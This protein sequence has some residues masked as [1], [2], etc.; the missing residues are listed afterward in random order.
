MGA[1]PW[2]GAIKYVL[3][4]IVLIGLLIAAADLLFGVHIGPFPEYKR[5]GALP[6]G[7]QLLSSRQLA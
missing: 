2:V 6:S 7:E 4:A 5:T 3:G 1:A